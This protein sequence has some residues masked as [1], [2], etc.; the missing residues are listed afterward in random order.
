MSEPERASALS[1]RDQTRLRN[2]ESEN[3]RLKL[4]R[5]YP[6]VAVH[7]E[8][9][10]GAASAEEQM[11]YLDALLHPRAP[12]TPEPAISDVDMNNPMRSPDDT[13]SLPPSSVMTE[14]EADWILKAWGN[15]PARAR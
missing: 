2:L 6:G 4:A 3:E 10:Y 11:R 8:K 12:G 1:Q 15:R 13:I 14:Q 5:Q 7:F 9:I